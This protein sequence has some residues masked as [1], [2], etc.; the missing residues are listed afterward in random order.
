MTDEEF[1]RYVLAHSQTEKAL[2]PMAYAR[3]LLELAGRN[4]EAMGCDGDGFVTIMPPTAES[5]VNAAK[6]R[7]SLEK[8]R[9]GVLSEQGNPRWID[10]YTVRSIST[11]EEKA[12]GIVKVSVSAK[13][14]KKGQADGQAQ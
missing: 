14:V 8:I 12:A 9:S 7:L 10:S 3:R 6:F 5:L 1:L 2:F 13:V 11:D 4:D